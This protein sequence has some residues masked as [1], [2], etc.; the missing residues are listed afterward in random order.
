MA[1]C[2]V[3]SQPLFLDLDPDDFDEATASVA[4]D[5][6]TVPDDLELRCGCHYH[7]QCLLDLSSQVALS[8]KCPSCDTRLVSTPDGPSA[9]NPIF[10]NRHQNPQILTRYVNEGGPQDNLDILPLITEE[11]YLD[12]NPT[13][14]PA[15]AYLVKLTN[16]PI[17]IS[18]ID[19][20]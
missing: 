4:G 14:R 18:R 3:C 11:A 8:L 9:T 17:A 1:T 5:S 2:K 12:A 20:R 15:R 7:W 19:S 16:S 6:T 10:P 13:A